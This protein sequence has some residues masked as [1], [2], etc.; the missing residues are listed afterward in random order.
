M[1]ELPIL[2][3]GSNVISILEK[4]KSQTRR[5]NGL[6]EINEAPDSWRP[7]TDAPYD[8]DEG[9]GVKF[10]C[11]D[12]VRFIK[13][14]FGRPGDGLWVKENFCTH[15]SYDHLKPSTL[16]DINTMHNGISFLADVYNGEKSSWMGKTRP[17][18][19]LPRRFSRIDLSV[20]SVRMEQVNDISE[21][22]A[23]AEGIEG[24]EEKFHDDAQDYWKDYLFVDNGE[25]DFGGGWF[26]GDPISSFFSLWDS[27]N[28][29]RGY[30]IKKRPWSWVYDF[31]LRC[32]E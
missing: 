6:E 19:Y 1:N 26:M 9:Y 18:I 7:V 8:Y 16:P 32:S 20:I 25:A 4:L 27:I 15:T 2:F 23:I 30:G 29:E 5:L 28:K 10:R 3:T 17:S 24:I 12:K 21:D 13:A 22:D 11:G 14:P 31:E